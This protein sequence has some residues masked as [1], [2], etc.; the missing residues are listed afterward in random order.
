MKEKCLYLSGVIVILLIIFLLWWP[1]PDYLEVPGTADNLGSMVHVN[2]HPDRNHGRL[3][4]TSVGV[5]PAHPLT[6]LWARMDP[7]DSIDRTQDLTGGQNGQTY[8][9]VQRFYMR[10]AINEAIYTAF[11]A[12]HRYV[13]RRYHGIYVVSIMK[14]SYLDHRL[15]VGD[16]ITQI[17]HHH[18]NS[19]N[20]YQKY[21][22]H[23]HLKSVLIAFR[24]HR[25]R[26]RMV[27]TRLIKLPDR[28][29][30]LGVVLTDDDSVTTRISVHVHSGQI[31]G[32]SAGLMFT[33]QIYSQLK[34]LNLTRGRRIAGTGT[35]NSNGQ[36]GEIGGIDKKI[37][38]AKNRGATVFFAPY[39]RPTR[40]LLRIE[41]DHLTNYQLAVRTA[42]KYAPHMKIVPVTNFQDALRYLQK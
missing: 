9:R 40:S 33:L 35:I 27:R 6:Y 19:A 15:Q 37:I 21:L 2:C 17:N 25:H 3:F 5:A 30:G 22:A 42:H 12:A 29:R 36:V 39:M 10:D 26:N 31:G 4:M 23:K 18:F 1:L 13:C 24:D 41:P 14:N 11:K 16:T 32:P 34:S 7:V 20:G 8:N 38:A 28:R